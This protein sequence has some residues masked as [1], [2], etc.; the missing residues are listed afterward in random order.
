MPI[1]QDESAAF[2]HETGFVDPLGILP[3]RLATDVPERHVGKINDL[4]KGTHCRA[5]SV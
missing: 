1:D 3:T 2:D 5:M 4:I